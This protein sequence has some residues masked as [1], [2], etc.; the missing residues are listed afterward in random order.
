MAISTTTITTVTCDGHNHSGCARTAQAVFSNPRTVA[1]NLALRHHWTRNS[2]T[3]LCP[4]CSA[5]NENALPA[6]VIQLRPRLL[7]SLAS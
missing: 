2:G 4:A 1:M 6:D 5:E 7:L 3:D